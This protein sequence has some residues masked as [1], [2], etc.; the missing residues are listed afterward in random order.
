MPRGLIANAVTLKTGTP[1]P[2][3]ST[4]N[5]TDQ[6]YFQNTGDTRL[7]VRNSGATPR[8]VTIY[9]SRLISGQPVQS[10]TKTIAAGVT[11]GFGPFPLE[12]FGQSINVDVAHAEL[13]LYT[14]D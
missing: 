6:H 12:D 8:I 14:L 9:V 13:T 11:E 10:I 5:T 3:P 7:Y 2:V 1:L 4:G